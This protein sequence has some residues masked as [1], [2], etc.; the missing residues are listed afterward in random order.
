MGADGEKPIDRRPA[1]GG[2][3]C[4]R[5]GAG[6]TL[7]SL[8]LDGAWFCGAACAAGRPAAGGRQFRVPETRL[9]ARPKRHFARRRPVELNS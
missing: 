1:S 6:L 9:Y 5:C 8:K 7:A 4:E 2:G 3:S